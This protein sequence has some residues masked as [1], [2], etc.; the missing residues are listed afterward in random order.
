MKIICFVMIVTTM[1]GDA[2]KSEIRSPISVCELLENRLKYDGQIVAVR[3]VVEG[4]TEGAALIGDHC[5]RPIVTQGYTWPN[6]ISLSY[7]LSLDSPHTVNF[8]RNFRQID[9]I[10]RE[11]RRIK[12]KYPDVKIAYTYVGLF[13]TRAKL[14]QATNLTGEFVPAGF[15]HLGAC[16]AQLVIQTVR[17][18][19]VQSSK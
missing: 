5:L 10:D 1:V 12:Q 14:G 15:G 7:D 4:S 2:A 16:P 6:A 13:E 11:A 3:G 18:P 19:R 8:T 9:R 17:D